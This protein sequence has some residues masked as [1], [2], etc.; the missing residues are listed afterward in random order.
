MITE[1]TKSR[2]NRA[3]P[4]HL[5]LHYTI[6]FTVHEGGRH[7]SAMN[8]S[9]VLSS[10]VNI[11]FSGLITCIY[12]H[13]TVL[14]YFFFFLDSKILQDITKV[15]TYINVYAK[16]NNIR[17]FSQNYVYKCNGSTTTCEFR[18]PCSDYIAT[19]FYINSIF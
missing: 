5:S 8:A 2:G 7:M 4:S 19:G 13:K 12:I 1:C 3:G 10:H 9:V 16:R 15:Y 17:S 18:L 14:F 6:S 11:I